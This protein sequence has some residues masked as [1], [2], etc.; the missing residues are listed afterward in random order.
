MLKF[1]PKEL[2]STL[3][4]NHKET[5]DGVVESSTEGKSLQVSGY[6]KKNEDDL[7]LFPDL[8]DEEGEEKAL[9]GK[10][11]DDP[12]AGEDLDDE[13]DD[14][15]EGGDYNAEQYF[16]D[17]GDDGGDDYDAGDDGGAEYF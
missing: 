14:D 6:Q 12:L 13:Y 1:F 7:G 17:G 15:E 8:S 11:G 9:D 3:D 16:D 5:D 2:W 4:P 10:E